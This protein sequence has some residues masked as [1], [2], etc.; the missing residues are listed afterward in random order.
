MGTR[1]CGVA[2]QCDQASPMVAPLRGELLVR[3]LL[4]RLGN[5]LGVRLDHLC[6]HV[7]R[8]VVFELESG[9]EG[10]EAVHANPFVRARNHYRYAR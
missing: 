2:W 3:L 10:A 7:C 8:K 5:L 6:V 1:A 9:E 4:I